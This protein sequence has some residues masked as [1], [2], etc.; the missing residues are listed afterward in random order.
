[1]INSQVIKVNDLTSQHKSAMYELFKNYYTA[2][3]PE[4][5]HDDLDSKHCSILLKSD[6]DKIQGFTT[7]EIIPIEANSSNRSSND[8]YSSETNNT[9]EGTALFSGDTILHHDYW[10]DQTL[11]W[12]WCKLAGE[13]KAQSP[14]TP[15]YWFL[16][17]KGH[18]TYRYLPVFSRQFYPNHKTQTPIEMKNRMDSL[19][20]K[21]FGYAYQKEL[22][23]IRFEHSKGH[24]NDAFK[25]VAPHLE[26][27]PHV[28]FFLEKN[29]R[30]DQGD[31]LVCMTELCEDNLRFHA[32]SAFLEGMQTNTPAIIL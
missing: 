22:G 24:L 32:K 16:I 4:Q 29:T 20:L 11:P 21:K 6:N 23:L 8:L 17:V 10:G 3:S 1:M 15:L 18:R 25:E 26:K 14:N 28:R 7:L 2:V 27:N 5:F 31:E 13:I 12:A 30:Y 19:A 9:P